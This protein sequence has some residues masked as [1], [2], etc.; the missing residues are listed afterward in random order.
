M[1]FSENS[2]QAAGYLRQAIPMMVKHKV[3]PNPLNYTLWYSYCSNVFPSLNKQLDKTIERFGTCPPEIAE[4]LFF[5]HISKLDNDD[6]KQLIHLQKAFSHMVDDLSDSMD[7]TAK[8]TNSY[9]QALMSNLTELSAHDTDN[10]ITPVL[11]KLSAN[12]NAIYTANETFRGQLSA[13]QSEISALKAELKSSKKEAHTDPL[14]GLYNRRVFEA[15][16]NQFVG[17]KNNQD[18]ITLIMM[19]VDKFKTFNDT[20]GHLVGDQILKYIGKLLKK[21]CSKPILPVRLGGE[22]FALL[23]PSFKLEQG[24]AFAENIRVKL[25]AIPF[26]SK[27]TGERIPAVTASFGVAQ[28]RPNDGLT[29]IIERADKALYAAKNAG[30]NQVKLAAN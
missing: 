14:T 9:S 22:E 30:R 19:D 17:N 24:K 10:A 7:H 20:H 4:K 15:I 12:A 26:S 5:R 23:C 1:K 18:N 6:K 29:N 8:Q 16:Y 2:D 25:A 13:A 28:K 21:E 27:R 11:N 3:V